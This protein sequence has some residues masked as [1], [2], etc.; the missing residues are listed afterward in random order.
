[1]TVLIGVVLN[2]CCGW[3]GA[4]IDRRLFATWYKANCGTYLRVLDH[5]RSHDFG[6]A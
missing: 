1:M 2:G 5:I 4:D 6:P 3:F